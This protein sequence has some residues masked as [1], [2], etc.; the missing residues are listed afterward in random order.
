MLVPAG[1]KYHRESSRLEFTTLWSA[2]EAGLGLFKWRDRSNSKCN[3]YTFGCPVKL[4]YA[5]LSARSGIESSFSHCGVPAKF[6]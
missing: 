4:V 2:C 6:M 3:F 5:R 1:F